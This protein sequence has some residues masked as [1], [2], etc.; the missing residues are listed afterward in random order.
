MKNNVN[1]VN[2]LINNGGNFK[3]KD[4]NLTYDGSYQAKNNKSN[5]VNS[6]L[7]EKN[8][9]TG[10]INLNF[11]ESLET[12]KMFCQKSKKLELKI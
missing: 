8:M 11:N 4:V 7:N 3:G 6:V 5:I 9:K 10:D 2:S 1:S 12:K